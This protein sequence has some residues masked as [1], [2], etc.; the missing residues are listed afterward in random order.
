MISK[1]EKRPSAKEMLV[2]IED[3]IC[4]SSID[5]F[6][7]KPVSRYA[8]PF[9]TNVQLTSNKE[10][11]ILEQFVQDIEQCYFITLNTDTPYVLTLLC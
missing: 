11:V 2:M 5:F 7:P 6:I 1:R 10:I 8:T 3:I 9:V 4:Q